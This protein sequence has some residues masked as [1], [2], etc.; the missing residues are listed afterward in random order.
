MPKNKNI[1][2]PNG[3][4]IQ[5][6]LMFTIIEPLLLIINGLYI[7]VMA[8]FNSLHMC[9]RASMCNVCVKPNKILIINEM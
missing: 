3:Q 5:V 4:Y 9:G 1:Q 6:N 8:V 7:Q 2:R